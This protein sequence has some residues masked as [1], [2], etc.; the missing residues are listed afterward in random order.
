MKKNKIKGKTHI[1]KTNPTPHTK[2]KNMERKP[3]KTKH[4]HTPTFNE[5]K[6]L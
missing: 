4:K 5:N 2:V 6:K 3:I 1:R